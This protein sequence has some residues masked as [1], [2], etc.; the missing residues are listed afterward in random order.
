MKTWVIQPWGTGRNTSLRSTVMWLASLRMNLPDSYLFRTS[1]VLG[2]NGILFLS[3]T[4]HYL[5]CRQLVF[6]VALLDV[7]E[8]QA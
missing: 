4:E 1:S 6:P 3:L 8:M 5:H 2:F 7:L